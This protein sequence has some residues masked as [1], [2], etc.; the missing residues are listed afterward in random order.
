MMLQKRGCSKACRC[1]N[2]KSARIEWVVVT[3]EELPLLIDASD[4]K[5]MIR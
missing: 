1:R 3:N 4:K 2:P 5:F